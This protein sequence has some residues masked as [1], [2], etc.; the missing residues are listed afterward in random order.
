[1]PFSVA[2]SHDHP[3][4]VIPDYCNTG[5]LFRALVAINVAVLMGAFLR[6]HGWMSG[7]HAFIEAAV[8]V[9]VAALASMFSLCAMRR[10]I[11]LLEPQVQRLIGILVPTLITGFLAWMLQPIVAPVSPNPQLIVVKATIAAILF[12]AALQHYFALRARASSPALAEA[13]LQALQARIRPHFLFNSLNAVLS[14]IRSEPRKAEATLE[15]LSDLFRVLFRD[16]RD[17]TTLADEIQLC[18]QY[19]AIEKVRLGDRL[20]VEWDTSG[21]S[22]DA[23]HRAQVPA[24]LLQ[25]LLENAVHHGIEPS[26]ELGTIRIRVTR[27]LDRIEISVT[28]PYHGASASSGNQ[29]ALDNVR[30][31]LSLLY[32]VEAQ[33]ITQI[34]QDK[35]LL[36]LRFPYRKVV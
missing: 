34:T 20:A 3:G 18:E 22:E 10:R 15:D 9:E 35:F 8:L 25:P 33:L 17:I 28:N 24:L 30:E 23:L 31:R 6:T 14:L 26:A 13:R 2:A 32:D 4:S 19:L 5:I 36:R 27:V 16:A 29:M 1:M 11:S 12:S 21:L 7:F